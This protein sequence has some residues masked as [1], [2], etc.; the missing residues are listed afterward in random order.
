MLNAKKQNL[1]HI[2]ALCSSSENQA[3][4]QYQVYT[5]FDVNVSMTKIF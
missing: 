1:F 3:V 4:L 2:L 5:K